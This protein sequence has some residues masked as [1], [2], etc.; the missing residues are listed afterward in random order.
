M[1]RRA[2]C[3]RKLGLG[4]RSCNLWNGRWWVHTPILFE[5]LQIDLWAGAKQDR[6]QKPLGEAFLARGNP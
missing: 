5:P 1:K 4:V 6:R 2:Q 3:H